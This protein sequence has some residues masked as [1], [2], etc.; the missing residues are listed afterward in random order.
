MHPIIKNA[1]RSNGPLIMHSCEPLLLSPL[2]Q[3]E[4]RQHECQPSGSPG[5]KAAC[6]NR[7][8]GKSPASTGGRGRRAPG[9][10]NDVA[11]GTRAA[12][13]AGAFAAGAGAGAGA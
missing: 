9:L 7:R 5:D 10:R 13:S 1:E 11:G 4:E 12:A 6:D 2:D 3:E 8:S